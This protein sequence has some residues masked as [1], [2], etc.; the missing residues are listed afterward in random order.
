MC[1]RAYARVCVCVC[2]E[3]ILVRECVRPTPIICVFQHH[4][5]SHPMTNFSR[6]TRQVLFFMRGPMLA[7][8]FGEESDQD[9]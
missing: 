3:R 4:R 9:A 5:S 8:K 2:V 1:I 7:V 6:V